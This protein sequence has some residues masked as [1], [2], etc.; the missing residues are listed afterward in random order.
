M[1]KKNRTKVNIDQLSKEILPKGTHK[2]TKKLWII[3]GELRDDEILYIGDV[4]LDEDNQVRFRAA[5]TGR[6]SW[7]KL[8]VILV[9]GIGILYV[10]NG[11]DFSSFLNNLLD[12]VKVIA[13]AHLTL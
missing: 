3:D 2:S 7:R 8:V 5:I 12:L 4:G 10:L 13:N 1:G 6:M 11:Q 9:I